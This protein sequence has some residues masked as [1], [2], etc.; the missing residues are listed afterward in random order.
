MIAA[1]Y[2]PSG[3]VLS[4]LGV[5]SFYQS[6]DENNCVNKIEITG[7]QH[8]VSFWSRYALVFHQAD[9]YQYDGSIIDVLDDVKTKW[10]ENVPSIHELMPYIKKQIM[11]YNLHIIGVMAGYSVSNTNKYEPYVYQILGQDIRRINT[12]GNGEITYNCVF[13]EKGT[14]IGRIMREVKVK[15]GDDWEE[16]LPM[17]LRCDLYSI[18]K[19][20]EIANFLL[21]TSHYLK[22]INSS[23]TL[24]YN[25]ESVMITSKEFIIE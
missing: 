21:R 18:H 20:R 7:H 6:V 9:E 8:V 12:N 11:D 17:Q 3:I 10:T 2:T 25:V 5:D 23:D 19:A 4:T 24:N 13:F 15:N 1:V 22:N 16:L 14:V